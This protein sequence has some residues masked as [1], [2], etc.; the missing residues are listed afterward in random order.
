MLCLFPSNGTR[1]VHS[2]ASHSTEALMVW[3]ASS[4]VVA[5]SLFVAAAQANFFSD[6][7]AAN[8]DLKKKVGTGI[9]AIAQPTIDSAP[10]AAQNVLDD[11]NS[12][13]A[14]LP[15]QL[16]PIAWKKRLNCAV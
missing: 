11:A 16:V 1:G 14:A 7:V 8:F 13:P 3:R 4:A 15:A 9:S 2:P 5:V 10:T 12:R 6:K